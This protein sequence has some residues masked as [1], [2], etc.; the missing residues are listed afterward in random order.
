MLYLSRSNH[1]TD[2]F[3]WN[4]SLRHNQVQVIDKYYHKLKSFRVFTADVKMVV[5]WVYTLCIVTDTF[6]CFRGTCCL[7]FQGGRIGDWGSNFLRKVWKRTVLHGVA[8]QK[9]IIIE[10]VKITWQNLKFIVGEGR[11]IRKTLWGL[12]ILKIRNLIKI[13][14]F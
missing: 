1:H 7:L 4:L 5:L 3:K 14:S 6:R 10:K 2:T 9:T 13:S 8:I 12:S 11:S